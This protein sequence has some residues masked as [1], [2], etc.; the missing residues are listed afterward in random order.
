M[1]KIRHLKNVMPNNTNIIYLNIFFQHKNQAQE[2]E[3]N[4]QG[5]NKQIDSLQQ[6]YQTE[7]WLFYLN[8]HIYVYVHP[9]FKYYHDIVNA[10]MDNTQSNF[11]LFEHY[12]QYL[13]MILQF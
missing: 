5:L 7:V 11:F 10:C 6:S 4:I 9:I 12:F 8:L 3:D 2:S 1:Q 13:I